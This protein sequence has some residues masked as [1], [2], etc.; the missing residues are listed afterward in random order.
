MGME[1]CH[2][3]GTGEAMLKVSGEAV[4]GGTKGLCRLS[5]GALMDQGVVFPS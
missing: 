3:G 4:P 1:G 5:Q 2:E